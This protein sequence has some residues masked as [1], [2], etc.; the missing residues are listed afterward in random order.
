LADL[1]RRKY[2]SV[3]SRPAFSLRRVR[4]CP[5]RVISNRN[6][7]A[8]ARVPEAISC[9]FRPATAAERGVAHLVPPRNSFYRLLPSARRTLILVTR[10]VSEGVR[11]AEVE[12]A[13]SASRRACS[14][15][16]NRIAYS[17]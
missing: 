8:M 6:N 7:R 1:Q 4:P 2:F 13:E 14:R 9:G 16:A 10:R 3:K 17:S 5:E 12:H 15:Y 11:S